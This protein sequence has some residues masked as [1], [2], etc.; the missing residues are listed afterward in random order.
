MAGFF[1]VAAERRRGKSLA[2]DDACFNPLMEISCSLRVIFF[3]IPL[4]MGGAYSAASA[5]AGRKSSSAW[6][7]S[8]DW[9]VCDDERYI[10]PATAAGD[11]DQS[12]GRISR[13]YRHHLSYL[14]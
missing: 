8:F 2:D 3:Y 12:A 4:L 9:I 10:P 6:C 14:S 7:I 1:V 13:S 5:L 11:D